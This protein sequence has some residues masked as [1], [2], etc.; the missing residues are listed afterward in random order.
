MDWTLTQAGAF[1]QLVTKL[2]EDPDTA[3]RSIT[4]RIAI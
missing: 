1:Y 4:S 2:N 3:A